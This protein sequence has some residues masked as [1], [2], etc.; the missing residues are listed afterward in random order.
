MR[1]I[2]DL[3]T[4]VPTGWEVPP[5]DDAALNE[6]IQ[7][8][9]KPETVEKYQEANR[10]KW[11]ETATKRACLDWRVGRITMAGALIDGGEP[12][13]VTDPDEVTLLHTFWETILGG[14]TT[15]FVGFGIRNFD[16]PWLLGRS[17]VLG[18]A[19]GLKSPIRMPRYGGG[20]VTDWADILSNYG[21]FETRGW[22]LERYAAL[23]DLPE[24]PVG[25]G[26]DMP[27]LYADGK[28][29]EIREHLVADLRTT[30][31]LDQ[32]LRSVYLGG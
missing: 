2:L 3:E 27:R 12:F 23:Y 8:R 19:T 26:E 4:G 14:R 10:Q 6:G 20:D 21:S 5:I 15:H 7:E 18:V 31:A 16:I 1:A 9:F 25:K 11:V 28:I 32:R 30:H 24:R 17:S 29:E 13:T 22:T